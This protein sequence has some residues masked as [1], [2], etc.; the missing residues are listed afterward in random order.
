MHPEAVAAGFVTTRYRRLTG[1]G[2]PRPGRRDFAHERVEVAR[3]DSANAGS[4][5]T[6][7]HGEAE[8]PRAIA[9]V[10]RQE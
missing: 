9:E 8:F 4:L 7:P 5:L 2:E 3:S 6:A 1:Q 10:E